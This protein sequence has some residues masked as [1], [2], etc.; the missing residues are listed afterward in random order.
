MRIDGSD[1]F[2]DVERKEKRRARGGF[3]RKERRRVFDFQ[4]MDTQS[5]RICIASFSFF[6]YTIPQPDRPL[7]QHASVFCVLFFVSFAL[8]FLLNVTVA[9]RLSLVVACGWLFVFLLI[10]TYLDSFTANTAVKRFVIF[11]FISTFHGRYYCLFS[12]SFS[13]FLS[14]SVSVSVSAVISKTILHF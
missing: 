10:R 8:P 1:P 6:R 12:S 13:T 2:F 9:C 11:L 14:V 7:T 5:H 3:E 4:P